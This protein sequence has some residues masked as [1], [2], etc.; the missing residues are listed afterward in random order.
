MYARQNIFSV[1]RNGNGGFGVG[2]EGLAV[3][4]GL[5]F[6]AGG[7]GISVTVHKTQIIIFFILQK[8]KPFEI[9]VRL[10]ILRVQR[11]I[12][13]NFITDTGDLLAEGEAGFFKIILTALEVVHAAV[14]GIRFGDCG[15][16]RIAAAVNQIRAL[17]VI[18]LD[19]D[20][21]AQGVNHVIIPIVI[22]IRK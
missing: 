9:F 20:I 17:R 15:S 19:I 18:F 10:G 14:Q 8:E 22:K 6:A 2:L 7:E 3:L 21:A 1:A 16:L 11:V 4:P 5:K 12:E 13:K